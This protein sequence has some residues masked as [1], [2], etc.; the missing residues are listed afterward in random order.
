MNPSSHPS[1]AQSPLPQP[2]PR[3]SI[4]S[5]YPRATS[6]AISALVTAPAS[7][8]AYQFRK[9]LGKFVAHVGRYGGRVAHNV[10]KAI[11]DTPFSESSSP[12]DFGPNGPETFGPAR[13]RSYETQHLN[14][15]NEKKN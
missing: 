7:I 1:R 11:K 10:F 12:E 9:P 5:R 2:Q 6:A 15:V 3:P 4:W 13:Q 14:T 8:L